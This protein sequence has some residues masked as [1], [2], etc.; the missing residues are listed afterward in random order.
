VISA[1]TMYSLCT[2]TFSHSLALDHAPKVAH[3][4]SSALQSVPQVYVFARV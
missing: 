2:V 3:T 4:D 1:V